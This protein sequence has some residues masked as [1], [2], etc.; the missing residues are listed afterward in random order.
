MFRLNSSVSV[1]SLLVIVLVYFSLIN[2]F[3]SLLSLS[4]TLH[5][6]SL[7]LQQSSLFTT[8]IS[9]TVRLYSNTKKTS[10]SLFLQ[11]EFF[12]PIF[13]LFFC[14]NST[15]NYDTFFREIELYDSLYCSFYVLQN[16]YTNIFLPMQILF[17]LWHQSSALLLKTQ[18]HLFSLV[19]I[20]Q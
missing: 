15:Y 20:C 3:F 4:P 19:S 14:R 11:L 18:P 6:R 5:H 17:P 9:S 13:C 7:W 10:S 1:T 8:V 16:S 2:V 12:M